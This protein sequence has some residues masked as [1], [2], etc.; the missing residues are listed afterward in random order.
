M[1][2]IKNW[3]PAY[4]SEQPNLKKDYSKFY[5]WLKIARIQFY[6][7]TLIAYGLGAVCASKQQRLKLSTPTDEQVQLTKILADKSLLEEENIQ[8]FLS[9]RLSTSGK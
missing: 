8:Q 4:M 7:M 2:L 5:A 1:L 9:S 3:R 6:P